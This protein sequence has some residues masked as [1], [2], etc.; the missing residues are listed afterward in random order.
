MENERYIAHA[1][2]IRSATAILWNIQVKIEDRKSAEEL[3]PFLWEKQE[4][5][6]TIEEI[7]EQKKQREL[8][9][10]WMDKNM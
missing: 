4:E 7:A 5:R 6:L 9:K 1:E 3:W 10:K 8:Q 2:L